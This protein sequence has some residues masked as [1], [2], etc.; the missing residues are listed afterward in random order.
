LSY[1]SWLALADSTM[2]EKALRSGPVL[3]SMHLETRRLLVEEGFHVLGVL[4]RRMMP[5]S[6]RLTASWS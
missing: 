4:G 2:A 6:I 5:F 3:G 1:F